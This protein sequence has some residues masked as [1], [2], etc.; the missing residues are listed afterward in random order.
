MGKKIDIDQGEHWQIFDLISY[1]IVAIDGD[2]KKAT[3]ILITAMSIQNSV[4]VY[5]TYV[6][7]IFMFSRNL[8]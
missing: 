8:E 7:K 6:V 5:Y 4:F 1:C 2:P 3:E